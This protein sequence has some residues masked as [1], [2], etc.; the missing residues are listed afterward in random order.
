MLFLETRGITI[1]SNPSALS[2]ALPSTAQPHYRQ[3]LTHTTESV[4]YLGFGLQDINGEAVPRDH[5]GVSVQCD[6]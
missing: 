5:Y 4:C 1:I 3:M 2:P 6:F